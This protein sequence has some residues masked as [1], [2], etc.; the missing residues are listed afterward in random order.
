MGKQGKRNM[1]GFVF[2]DATWGVL[3]PIEFLDPRLGLPKSAS[4]KM[5]DM[6]GS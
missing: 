6:P 5:A 2:L 4:Q 1:V 3:A